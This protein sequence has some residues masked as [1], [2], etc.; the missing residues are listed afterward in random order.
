MPIR[1]KIPTCCGNSALIIHF[2]FAFKKDYLDE[3]SA[4]GYINPSLY[5]RAGLLYLRKGTMT[6]TCAFG[7]KKITIKCGGR[8][9][10]QQID[11]FEKMAE[12]VL[13]SSNGM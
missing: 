3:F 4:R 1:Q 8:N 2:D 9:C 5:T 10:P 7:S 13:A 12:Q 6:A 11:E